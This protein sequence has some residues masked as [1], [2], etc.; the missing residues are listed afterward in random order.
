MFP[1]TV[2]PFHEAIVT[3]TFIG[4]PGRRNTGEENEAARKGDPKGLGG[5]RPGGARRNRDAR[6]SMKSNAAHHGYGSHAAAG[7]RHRYIR[8]GV[9]ADASVHGGKVPA[10]FRKTEG[11][12]PGFLPTAPARSAGTGAE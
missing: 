12:G 9:A 3:P 6:R 4:S 5:K 10:R 8:K 7:S 1:R 11:E 2:P